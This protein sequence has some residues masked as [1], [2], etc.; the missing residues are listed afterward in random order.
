MIEDVDVLVIGGG[1]IGRVL[2]RALPSSVHALLVDDKPIQVTKESFDARSIALSQSSIQ[3]LKM[4]DIWPFLAQKQTPIQAIHISEQGR[5][6]HARLLSQRDPLG[7]VVEMSDL[8]AQCVNGPFSSLAQATL[9]H[10][11][12]ETRCATIKTATKEHVVR[13]NVIVGADGADSFLRSCCQCPLIEKDYH[14]HALVVNIGLQRAHAHWAYERF[15][16]HGP[17]AMLPM[18]EQR[19]ALI[20]VNSP[21]RTL[22]LNQLSDEAFLKSLQQ[23]FGYRL[24]RFVKM[25]K[26]SVYPLFQK[27]MPN[28]VVD[29]VVF[30]G[31]AAHTLHPIAGQG[32]NLGLRDAA[33]LAQ[34]IIQ[35]GANPEALMHYQKSRTEDE[36]VIATSTDILIK[37]F[38]AKIPGLSVMRGL[39]LIALDHSTFLKRLISRY[40]SGYGGVVPDLVC[41]IAP[42]A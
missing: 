41:G 23:C 42:L 6:G 37:L 4:L 28:K 9:V 2:M 10:Y 33:M 24:G 36:Q 15:T 16:A 17:I 27:V 32:L 39:G 5:F 7:A 29:S 26:R 11:D 21:E 34:C 31:N 13:A 40:A 3:V 1:V 20:W 22:M 19:A 8:N 35:C 12:R 14:Q 38:G 25:G 30:I 18:S